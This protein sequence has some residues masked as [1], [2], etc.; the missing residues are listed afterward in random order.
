MAHV[1]LLSVVVIVAVN[2]PL[3][4]N[5][6][7]FVHANSLTWAIQK[8]ARFVDL[9]ARILEQQMFDEQRRNSIIAFCLVLKQCKNGSDCQIKLFPN[10]VGSNPCTSFLFNNKPIHFFCFSF[11]TFGK[12][13]GLL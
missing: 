9:I 4:P 10:P 7:C 1:L 2:S 12:N 13:K 11:C 8:V 6:F 3:D 5:L